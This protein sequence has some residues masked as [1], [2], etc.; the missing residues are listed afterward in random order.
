MIEIAWDI[1]NGGGAWVGVP[2]FA[3]EA[4]GQG[5]GTEDWE[6]AP[7]EESR[8]HCCSLAR[9]RWV[10]HSIPY[11]L[12]ILGISSMHAALSIWL[13]HHPALYQFNHLWVDLCWAAMWPR[14]TFPIWMNTQISWAGTICGRRLPRRYLVAPKHRFGIFGIWMLFLLGGRDVH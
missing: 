2:G 3:Q 14:K 11:C 7:R 5:P 6:A 12:G 10:V 4:A 1:F 8:E 9:V 13:I